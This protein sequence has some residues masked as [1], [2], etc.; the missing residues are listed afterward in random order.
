MV[1]PSATLTTLPVQAKEQKEARE[2]RI[3][4]RVVRRE[5]FKASL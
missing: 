1:S 3:E 5:R 4:E 2:R